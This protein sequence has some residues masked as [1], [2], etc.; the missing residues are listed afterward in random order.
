MI[1]KTKTKMIQQMKSL[2]TTVLLINSNK[3]K[4]MFR[5]GEEDQMSTKT[6]LLNMMNRKKINRKMKIIMMKLMMKLIWNLILTMMMTIMIIS[7]NKKMTSMIMMTMEL[8]MKSLTT[9]IPKEK[10]LK[11]TMVKTKTCSR[12]IA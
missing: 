1:S 2:M 7:F 6:V 4:A 9:V 8:V 3:T 5:S 10:V 11:T 12:L